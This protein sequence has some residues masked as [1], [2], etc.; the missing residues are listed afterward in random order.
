L[1]GLP[2]REV[3]LLPEPRWG[4]R[5][6]RFLLADAGLGDPVAVSAARVLVVVG[7]GSARRTEKA[8]GYLDDRAAGFDAAIEGALSSG[9]AGARAAVDLELGQELLAAAAVVL[10]FIGG[11][12]V[13]SGRAVIAADLAHAADTF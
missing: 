12:V 4:E 11:A 13:E 9:D 5:G 3:G 7:D 6:G 2:G 10:R 1:S 8:P